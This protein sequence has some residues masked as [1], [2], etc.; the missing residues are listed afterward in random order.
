MKENKRLKFILLS[1]TL[2]CNEPPRWKP[3]IIEIKSGVN[4]TLALKY[5]AALFYN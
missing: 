3:Y 4:K 1:P 2:C 5:L